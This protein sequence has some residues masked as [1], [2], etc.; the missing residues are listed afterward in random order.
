G[1]FADRVLIAGG[2]AVERRVARNQRALISRERKAYGL[3]PRF[4]A[5]DGS[6]LGAIFGDRAQPV[7]DLV[8]RAVPHLQRV[9]ERLDGLIFYLV[10]S[11]VPELARVEHSVEQRRRIAR[12]ETSCDP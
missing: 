4:G 3:Y 12:A 7:D 9:D 10:H 2:K 11:P 1:R 6:E 8:V 5:E